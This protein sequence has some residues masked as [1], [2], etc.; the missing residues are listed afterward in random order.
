MI[1][2][3]ATMLHTKLSSPHWK[4][5]DP[6]LQHHQILA[7][8]ENGLLVLPN[9]SCTELDTVSVSLQNFKILDLEEH[10]KENIA[11][12]RYFDS[13]ILDLFFFEYKKVV[14]LFVGTHPHLI[15]WFLFCLNFELFHYDI[16]WVREGSPKKLLRTCWALLETYATNLTMPGMDSPGVG[17]RTEELFAPGLLV[18][19]HQRFTIGRPTPAVGLRIRQFLQRMP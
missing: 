9:V 18:F 7:V 11:P 5:H 13:H 2:G 1:H 16:V 14:W 17:H 12:V 3:C 8:N 6:P 19:G 15:Q 10:A 4:L